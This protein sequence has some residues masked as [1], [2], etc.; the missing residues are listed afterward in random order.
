[1]IARLGKISQAEMDRTFN[2]GLG[3]V[4]IVAASQAG[5]VLAYLRRRRQPAYVV[6]EVKRGGIGVRF[7]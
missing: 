7:L 1:M 5:E 4:A 2:N 6:G 3:M